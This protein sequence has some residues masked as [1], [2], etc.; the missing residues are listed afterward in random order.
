[1]GVNQSVMPGSGIIPDVKGMGL[2]DAVYILENVGLKV[3]VSGK[4]KVF[5]QSIIAGT[6]SR[7]GQ[8]IELILN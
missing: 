3:K 8:L 1:M 5:N 7:K 6:A 2:K 4:G